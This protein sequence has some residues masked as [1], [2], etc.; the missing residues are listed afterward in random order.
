LKKDF[1][2]G[3]SVKIGSGPF[4][5]KLGKIDDVDDKYITILLNSIKVKLSL[6]SSKLSLAS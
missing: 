5:N 1:Q 3:D 2:F 4:K 6:S